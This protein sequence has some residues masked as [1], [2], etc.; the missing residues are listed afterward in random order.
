MNNRSPTR[1]SKFKPACGERSACQLPLEADVFDR[2][3][4][5]AL[6]SHT[7]AK[8]M[9]AFTRS[10]RWLIGAFHSRELFG[11]DLRAVTLGARPA[12]SMTPRRNDCEPRAMYS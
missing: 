7:C 9:L 6:G 12:L 8:T 2:V 4:A 1:T 10:L 11:S 5:A 3:G